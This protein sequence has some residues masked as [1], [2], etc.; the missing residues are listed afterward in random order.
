M[1]EKV[2]IEKE[3]IDKMLTRMSHEIL[4][5]GDNV[6]EI[7]LVGIKTRGIFLAK[8]L[9]QKLKEIDSVNVGVE[10]LDISFYR[11]DLEKK[12]LDPNVEE[13]KFKLDLNNKVVIIVDD[14]LY[15]GRTSRSAIDAIMSTSRPK[16][17]RLAILVDRGHRELPLRADYVG[18][19]IPTSS[20]ENIKVHL[21]EI[22]ENDEVVIIN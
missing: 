11:D 4:E 22:D 5:K 17:V 15:T 20:K 3:K 6:N 13:A 1:K 12:S 19:N 14:V 9:K 8:R 2:L 7:I 16:A 21:K 10:T 18:K